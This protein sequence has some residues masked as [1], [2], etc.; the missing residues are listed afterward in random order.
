M[1]DR[2]SGVVPAG[3]FPIPPP[4]VS[5]VL[6]LKLRS[7]GEAMKRSAQLARR[8][9]LGCLPFAHLEQDDVVLR[10]LPAKSAVEWPVGYVTWDLGSVD[11]QTIAPGMN[12]FV[13]GR[14]VHIDCAGPSFGLDR[15][16]ESQLL[17][18]AESLGGLETA[19]AVLRA[20]PAAAKVKNGA[21]RRALLYEAI[22]HA[23]PLFAA[24]AV[25][26]RYERDELGEWLSKHPASGQESHILTGLRVAHATQFDSNADVREAAWRIVEGDFVF[27]TTY[28]GVIRGPMRGSRKVNTLRYAVRYLREHLNTDARYRMRVW[29]AAQAVADEPAYAGDQHLTAAEEMRA[30]NPEGSYSCAAN[31][32]A[33]AARAPKQA[34]RDVMTAC[35]E[36]ARELSVEQDWTALARLL[37]TARSR[38]TKA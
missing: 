34:N 33:C 7:R 36:W 13:A 2:E 30:S 17:D 4:S 26:W 11:G 37:E 3:G 15:T 24:L 38:T 10:A 32:V 1:T 9:Y 22:A 16:L 20:R 35:I 6:L 18:Y 25:A 27:D 5:T 23:D 21:L 28:V 12:H 31:A 14:L 19:R 8:G 29:H